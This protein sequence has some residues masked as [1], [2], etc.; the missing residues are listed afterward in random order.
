MFAVNNTTERARTVAR[1]AILLALTV[2]AHAAG[3]ELS[4][5][6]CQEIF[7]VHNVD[8]E[9]SAPVGAALNEAGLGADFFAGAAPVALEPATAREL[10]DTIQEE[11]RSFRSAERP[12]FFR[13]ATIAYLQFEAAFAAGLGRYA[14]RVEQGADPAEALAA[15]FEDP[16]LQA[17]AGRFND[18][19]LPLVERCGVIADA[20]TARRLADLTRQAGEA[21]RSAVVPSIAQEANAALVAFLDALERALG[22]YAAAVDGGQSRVEALAAVIPSAAPAGMAA[23]DL[24]RGLL[25]R[26]RIDVGLSTVTTAG[27][28]LAEREC[29]D[30]LDWYRT[31]AATLT[32]YN[33]ALREVN[34]D[35]LQVGIALPGN[36]GAVDLDG[37]LLL[38]EDGVYRPLRNVP[39]A[40]ATVH[41]R[42]NNRGWTV[43]AFGVT[44]G[45]PG[46]PAP[47]SA[48]LMRDGAVTTIEV[49]GAFATTA[50]GVNDH[51]QVVG[52]YVEPENVNPVGESPA[53]GFLWHEGRFTLI[54]FPGAPITAPYEIDNA[55]RIVGNY[56]DADSVQH[57]FILEDGV[58]TSIDHPNATRS[59]NTNATRLVGIND[60]GWTVGSYGDD[61]GILH[62][63]VRDPSGAFMT[64]DPPGALAGAEASNINARRQIVGRY[65]DATPKLLSF[66]LEAPAAEFVTLD[67]LGRCD[68]AAFD[69]DDRGRILIAP[70]GTTDGTTCPQD[71]P[72]SMMSGTQR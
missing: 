5:E 27:M 15:L 8:Q 11:S 3:H 39:G 63:F 62:A 30:A 55:G 12:A 6:Q 71:A 32:D 18:V 68:T 22:D 36:L 46:D 25:E 17:A 51:G 14:R 52:G 66:F 49:P 72:E 40:L 60:D 19:W 56:N 69:I 64:I 70:T 43:G 44:P 9:R 4:A 53:R 31:T 16:R 28:P 29:T 1:I 37:G 26:C 59:P 23:D 13:Q 35:L 48:F 58:F 41:T 61:A 20:A 33:R 67:A 38:S 21:Q 24:I 57:G 34:V 42:M 50:L 2:A 47:L 7:A 65:Q 54:D 45:G 10:A